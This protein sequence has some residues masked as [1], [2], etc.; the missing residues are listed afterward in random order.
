MD[1]DLR[2][3]LSSRPKRHRSTDNYTESAIL[4]PI[5]CKEH[6]YHILFTQRSENLL[7]HGGQISF[8]GGV[9]SK[10]DNTLLDTALRE[11]CEEIGLRPE[12]ADVIGELDD[13]PTTTSSFLITPFVALIP[14]PYQFVP[15]PHEIIDIFDVSIPALLY[16]IPVRTEPEAIDG[17]PITEYFYDYGERTIWGAT[18]RIL[19]QLLDAIRTAK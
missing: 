9:R 6:V 10:A 11:S 12:D 7:H 13:T 17:E 5:F 3:I 14:H 2:Q 8:P 18:A 19:T 4:I 1:I 15:N 16:E